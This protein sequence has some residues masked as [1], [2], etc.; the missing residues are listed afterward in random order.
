MWLCSKRYSLKKQNQNYLLA[1]VTVAG[2]LAT[3]PSDMLAMHW[4]RPTVWLFK[5]AMVSNLW[6]TWIPR[7][8]SDWSSSFPFSLQVTFIPKGS[9]THPRVTKPPCFWTI[10]SGWTETWRESPAKEDRQSLHKSLWKISY[11]HFKY[12][13]I[14]LPYAISYKFKALWYSRASYFLARK[15]EDIYWNTKLSVIYMILS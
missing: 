8:S 5:A 11:F 7:T 13:T 15:C 1:N 12:L 2:T 3:T 6:S 14:W 9:T 4:Y 10:E